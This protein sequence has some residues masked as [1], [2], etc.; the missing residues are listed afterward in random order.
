MSL[1]WLI[2][3]SLSTGIDDGVLSPGLDPPPV[4]GSAV[5]AAENSRT[6]V[7]GTSAG[8]RPVVRTTF[9][10]SFDPPPARRI[11]IVAGLEGDRPASAQ[12]ARSL[13]GSLLADD[14]S[15][16]AADVAIDI[17]A[18]GNPDGL[19]RWADRPANTPLI[20]L[21]GNDR[22]VDDDRDRLLDEDGPEDIDGDG[23]VTTIRVPDPA[24]RWIANPDEPRLLVEI[25]KD[26]PRPSVRY[27]IHSEG[28][29]NDFSSDPSSTQ[30]DGMINE[31]GPGGAGPARN[32][33]HGFP[34]HSDANGPY[35]LSEPESRAIVDSILSQPGTVLLIVLSDFDGVRG[36]PD[37][38]KPPE[39]RPRKPSL[40]IDPDD[41]ALYQQL[42]EKARE[43]LALVDLEKRNWTFPGGHIAGWAYFH[44]GIP[45]IAI[46]VASQ[47]PVTEGDPPAPDDDGA[48]DLAWLAHSDSKPE[49]NGFI[50]WHPIPGHFEGLK[51]GQIGG[52]RPGFRELLGSE[53]KTAWGQGLVK[54][55]AEFSTVLPRIEVRAVADRKIG[56]GIYL[57][58][59]WLADQS[60]WPQRIAQA[61]R[62]RHVLPAR[63]TI[64]VEGGSVL[65]EGKYPRSLPEADQAGVRRLEWVV[66]AAEGS[67]VRVR[68]STELAG[69]AMAEKRLG[70]RREVF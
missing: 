55:L 15:W 41:V 3:L 14:L 62:N 51:G 1:C 8:G 10:G 34:E 40:K 32:F 52:F 16:L 39:G 11:A 6:E 19:A 56:K 66:S 35:P 5:T 61:R 17:F 28:S 45:A 64:E 57:V 47:P 59:A 7:I 49:L 25:G 46:P 38:G 2:L 69:D 26:S 9:A 48:R 67:T 65:G 24:G 54:L 60:R 18:E 43:H 53:E 63:V 70:V 20:P 68:V 4:Q 29:D 33:P 42:A 36:K 22:P 23:H 31:D 12:A 21:R 50:P 30:G 37:S 44:L 58:E 13:I 27:R